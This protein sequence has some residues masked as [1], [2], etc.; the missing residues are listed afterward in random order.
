MSYNAGSIVAYIQ[1]NKTAWD[2][3][4]GTVRSDIANLSRLSEN[5]GRK[6]L[7]LSATIV[8]VGV[9]AVREFGKFEHAMRI[10]TSVSNVSEK[11]FAQA[12]DKAIEVSKKWNVAATTVANAYLYLGRA[13]LTMGQQMASVEPIV[14]ASKA[15]LTDLEDTTE[16]VVNIIRAFNYEFE[17]TA[18]IVGQVTYA[19]NKSTQSLDDILIAL[20][21][22]G[23]PAQAANTSFQE[24]AAALSIAANQGIRGSKAGVALRFAFTSLM[25]PTKDVER[26]LAKYNIRIYDAENRMKPLPDLLEEIE[27]GLEGAT[28]RARNHALATI[29]G[30]RATST[31]LALLSAGSGAVR[32]WTENISKAGNEA[33]DVAKLQLKALAERWGLL[34]KQIQ[35]VVYALVDQFSP[36]LKAAIDN[37]TDLTKKTEE[38]IKAN[39]D[40]VKEMVKS[41]VDF[42]LLAAKIGLI[43]LLLPK[44]IQISAALFSAITNP[45]LLAVAAIYGLSVVFRDE[46]AS[47]YDTVKKF[48]DETEKYST[49]ASK[50]VRLLLEYGIGKF[51]V[52]LGGAATGAIAGSVM[53]MGPWGAG[54]GALAGG[55]Y[56]GWPYIKSKLGQFSS[57]TNKYQGLTGTGGVDSGLK[58]HLPAT[59]T[60]AT[61]PKEATLI[62]KL[63][64]FWKDNSAKWLETIQGD[65]GIPKDL[66]KGLLTPEQLA[67]MEKMEK[68]I[69]DLI[70][71]LGKTGEAADDAGKPLVELPKKV[72]NSFKQLNKD[73]ADFVQDWDMAVTAV[74]E[75]L[76]T[77][78]ETAENVIEGM[79]DSFRDGF[80]AWMDDALTFGN[81]FKNIFDRMR[82]MWLDLIATITTNSILKAIGLGQ[83]NTMTFQKGWDIYQSGG[84]WEGMWNRIFPPAMENYD[85][86]GGV[87]A[88]AVP[89]IAF[90]ITNEI[91]GAELAVVS[92]ETQADRTVLNA[93]MR[94]ASSNTMFRRTFVNPGGR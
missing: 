35:G 45:T 52:V 75:R 72:A 6:M 2:K 80:R 14:L 71:A 61:I 9:I 91:P 37:L 57:W 28:E 18:Q 67:L 29:V 39:K 59:S 1:L 68:I 79:S 69:N 13:G 88:K 43:L 12:S 73:W 11:E 48:W 7:A 22:A 94:L 63:K 20:S 49:D 46:F 86:V 41:I 36:G 8:G 40:Q 21:Y 31:W 84:G 30:T 33:E 70:A 17:D 10:A 5:L 51:G 60:T 87:M 44:L 16:G 34:K 26:E 27:K 85:A 77:V 93:T 83:S 64:S 90:N 42:G 78:Q 76:M 19:A 55:T 25:R 53:G 65:L 81:F 23:K 89:N 74:N 3:P 47:M 15:M 24:L 92:A 4:L 62:E 32:E 54:A 56:A 66:A 82:S 38:W 50:R 58:M